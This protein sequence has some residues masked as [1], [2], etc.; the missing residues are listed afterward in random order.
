MVYNSS[1]YFPNFLFV[2][3]V[4]SVISSRSLKKPELLDTI[5]QYE[6]EACSA[7]SKWQIVQ[8][9]YGSFGSIGEPCPSWTSSL[10]SWF[11]CETPV[12]QCPEV[13]DA[14]AIDVITAKVLD[15]SKLLSVWK[16]SKEDATEEC[17]LAK[18]KFR[19]SLIELIDDK[20]T[21]IIKAELD[22]DF[23][24]GL[25]RKSLYPEA[26]SEFLR[27]DDSIRSTKVLL[28]AKLLKE[29]D[30]VVR[31]IEVLQFALD[32]RTVDESLQYKVHLRLA[33]Y[34]SSS[35]HYAEKDI[36]K[37][38]ESA[39]KLSTNSKVFF[40]FAKFLDSNL[41]LLSTQQYKS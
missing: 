30:L 17:F 25:R 2:E 15:P 34:K 26:L 1:W 41:G 11:T 38:F 31:S 20:S 39:A 13:L 24:K 37:H 12:L 21:S 28:E 29:N 4:L 8:F 35:G 22:C 18:V 32:E 14:R 33:D 36:L 19:R 16:S 10:L 6:E 7:L 5:R 23:I 3:D 27:L 40:K 9:D